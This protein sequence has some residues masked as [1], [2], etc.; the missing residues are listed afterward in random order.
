M[1]ARVLGSL[2]DVPEEQWEA[3][4]ARPPASITGSRPW[5]EAALETVDRGCAPLLLA[6]REDDRLVG[7]M[8]LVRDERNAAPVLRFAGSPS[9]DLTD[10]LSLPGREAEVGAAAAVALRGLGGR[11]WDLELDDVDPHGTLAHAPRGMLPWSDG[12]AAPVIDLQH[13]GATTSARRCRR[14][15]REMRR[16]RASH[17]VEIRKLERARV[18]EAFAAFVLLRDA[19]LRALNRD[20]ADPPAA[21]LDAVVSRLAP[22]GRCAFMDL[23][24]D[25]HV[26]ARDLYLLD[27]TVAML[28]LRALDMRWLHASCGHLLLR[29]SARLLAAEG[30]DALDLGRGAEPYK[31]S[32]GAR[33][34]AL[35]RIRVGARVPAGAVAAG[36]R[37]SL[38][39]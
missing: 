4:S 2:D 24:V 29:E 20:L 13:A 17:V 23:A 1:E 15:N 6:L 9:N 28:W 12:S 25:G 19:R 10:A 37:A 27:G 36:E 18:L 33:H 11:G 30:F 8:T 35:G 22:L 7:L 39:S 38:S 26:V 14:L 16:L 5:A 21:F 34:R 32:F 31:L 3:L